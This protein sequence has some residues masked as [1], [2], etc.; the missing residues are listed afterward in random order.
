MPQVET[1]T[2]IAPRKSGSMRGWVRIGIVVSVII[3]FGLWLRKEDVNGKWISAGYE[4]CDMVFDIKQQGITEEDKLARLRSKM[5]ACQQRVTSMVSPWW[6]Y[7]LF[8]VVVVG[9]LWLVAWMLIAVRLGF[10][11]RRDHP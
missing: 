3:A 2:R 4:L 11:K 7:I 5:T 10:S 6:S 8:D 1:S 9:F